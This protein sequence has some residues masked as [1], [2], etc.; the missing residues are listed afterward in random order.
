VETCARN[1][2][3]K[4][5]TPGTLQ[6]HEFGRRRCQNAF[7]AGKRQSHEDRSPRCPARPRIRRI[8][9]S[10]LVRFSP[11]TRIL[12]KDLETVNIG[13]RAFDILVALLR[14]PNEVVT[15]RELFEQVWPNVNVD[16]GSLRVQIT[17]LRTS[18]DALVEKSQ[19]CQ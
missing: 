4:T 8:D 19:T 13:G 3:P 12:K 14:R 7:D 9:R 18:P 1:R 5:P 15:K 17:N 11:V 10:V 2:S 16:D 6:S